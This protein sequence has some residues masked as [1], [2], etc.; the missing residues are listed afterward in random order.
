LAE[1]TRR[2]TPSAAKYR[3]ADLKLK[4]YLYD[5]SPDVLAAMAALKTMGVALA[6]DTQRDTVLTHPKSYFVRYEKKYS[7]E[8]I[9]VCV[10]ILAEKSLRLTRHIKRAIDVFVVEA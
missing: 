5:L 6:S 2:D 10:D 3:T 9:P 8:T 1:E 7:A 4:R